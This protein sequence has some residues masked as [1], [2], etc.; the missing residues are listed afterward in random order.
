MK[1]LP[2][3]V[4]HPVINIVS[5]CQD[6]R[7][8]VQFH[9]ALLAVG[10][11]PRGIVSSPRAQDAAPDGLLHLRQGPHRHFW[12][13]RVSWFSHLLSVWSFCGLTKL[14]SWLAMFILTVETWKFTSLFLLFSSCL[15]RPSFVY[16]PAKMKHRRADTPTPDPPPPQEGSSSSSRC[17]R[18]ILVAFCSEMLMTKM[19]KLSGFLTSWRSVPLNQGEESWLKYYKRDICLIFLTHS[20]SLA[21]VMHVFIWLVSI[22]GVLRPL[23]KKHKTYCP[24]RRCTIENCVI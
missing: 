20:L 10:T 24:A 23:A 6:A 21:F 14:G 4:C 7:W 13:L 18:W 17:T 5:P 8:R 16:F 22:A 15:T 1:S 2:K 11:L 19:A 3:F 9:L 12:Q